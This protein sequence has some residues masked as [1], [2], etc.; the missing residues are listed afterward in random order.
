MARSSQG[1]ATPSRWSRPASPAVGLRPGVYVQSDQCSARGRDF[2]LVVAAR[3]VPTAEC[4]DYRMPL[5]DK[6]GRPVT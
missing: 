5:L 6:D 4:R 3:Y 1:W 2:C